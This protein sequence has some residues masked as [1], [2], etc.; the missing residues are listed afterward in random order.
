ME[1]EKN[2]PTRSWLSM[3]T[4]VGLGVLA[5][6]WGVPN[7]IEIL[8]GGDSDPNTYRVEDLSVVEFTVDDLS[9]RGL[10][11]GSLN[12]VLASTIVCEPVQD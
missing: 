12:Q 9:C 7:S 8:K 4:A 11:P 1:N 3:Y 6:G 10:T 2:S 5:F